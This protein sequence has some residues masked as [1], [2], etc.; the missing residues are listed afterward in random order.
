[1]PSF[2]V[3]AGGPGFDDL[4][5]STYEGRDLLDWD[6]MASIN[7]F[8]FRPFKSMDG[9]V[10]RCDLAAR[11][12][13][14]A[15]TVDSAELQAAGVSAKAADELAGLAA[16]IQRR[17]ATWNARRAT[18]PAKYRDVTNLALLSLAKTSL[19]G[20]TALDAW[21]HDCYPHQQTLRDIQYMDAALAALAADP[22]EPEAAAE[23]LVSV[24]SNWLGT[25]FSSS[26]YLYD[27]TRHDP[28]YYRVTWGG[29]GKQVAQFDMSPVLAKIGA[30]Y[31]SGAAAKVQKM[32]DA[33][34]LDLR[35]RV[36]AVN[37]TGEIVDLSLRFLNGLL[38][39]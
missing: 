24:G 14:L 8:F 25:V 36:N 37:D 28:D 17:G 6:Y 33:G 20:Y 35:M 23:A 27:L 21:D 13:D 38:K 34:A 10:L 7:K 5:H 16:G 2:E 15:A 3:S 30:G 11:G 12:A 19:K 18:V 22:V 39:P 26:V 31:F 1:M 29:L 4:C 9:A 32:R